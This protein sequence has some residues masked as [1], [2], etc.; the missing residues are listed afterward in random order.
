M[1]Q[2]PKIVAYLAHPVGSGH[3]P[4]DLERRQNN[5]ANA[6]AWLQFLVD[7]TGWA[8]NV[9]W[10]PYVQRLDENT[11]RARGIADDLACLERC[12]LLVATGGT[13]SPGMVAERGAAEEHGLPIVD[14]TSWGFAPPQIGAD[15]SSVRALVAAR[16]QIAL[17]RR[18]RRVWLPPL[19]LDEVGELKGNRSILRAHAVDHGVID[20]ILEAAFAFDSAEVTP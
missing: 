19:E 16:T 17:R 14:L 6:L 12:D 15:V 13:W 5:I 11:Y 20:R 3:A 10:L 8:V 2:A 7:V 9:P 4:E 1:T 18:P